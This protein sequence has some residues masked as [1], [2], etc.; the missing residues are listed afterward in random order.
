MDA[1]RRRLAAGAATERA[2]SSDCIEIP[3]NKCATKFVNKS[4]SQPAARRQRVASLRSRVSARDVFTAYTCVSS[5]VKIRER[6]KMQVCLTRH[7]AASRSAFSHASERTNE[8]ATAMITAIPA[9]VDTNSHSDTWCAA[10]KSWKKLTL[11]V[12]SY[13]SKCIAQSGSVKSE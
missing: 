4:T 13:F 11:R 6:V 7:L 12:Q 1:P 3:A 5:R 2:G 9:E 10:K 8:R